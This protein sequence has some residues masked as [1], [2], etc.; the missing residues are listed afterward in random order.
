MT[1]YA[2]LETAFAGRDAP[3]AFVDLDAMWS[4]A[5]EMLSRSSG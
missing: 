5:A 1:T 2:R 3:F 4:N